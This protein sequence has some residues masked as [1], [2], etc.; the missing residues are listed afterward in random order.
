QSLLLGANAPNFGSMY[1]LLDEFHKRTAPELHG[2]AIAQRLQENLQREVIDGQIR[3]FGAPPVEGLGTA[4]GFKIVV[5]DRGDS[6]FD[7]LQD[8]A[9]HVVSDGNDP[10]IAPGLRD[11]FT[12]FRART[13]WL[14]IDIDRQMVKS[15]GVSMSEVFDAMQ[16]YL[17][18][19]YINDF[20]RFGR[21]WQV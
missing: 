8:A 3:V 21:T 7:A 17:G 19:L 1:V 6:G 15:M 13:P 5:E 9:D 10:S 4:G 18:S 2:E 16:V 12:S 11:L 14:H 20:N